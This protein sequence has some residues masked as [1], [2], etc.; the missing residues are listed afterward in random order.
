[1]GKS[2]D[3]RYTGPNATDRKQVDAGGLAFQQV[4]VDVIAEGPS[5]WGVSHSELPWSLDNYE[6][7]IDVVAS[8][9]NRF[10]AIEC[11][12]YAR[13]LRFIRS[14]WEHKNRCLSASRRCTTV[15]AGEPAVGAASLPLNWR[16][17]DLGPEAA[18]VEL[19]QTEGQLLETICRPLCCA[20]AAYAMWRL[21][22]GLKTDWIAPM[23]VTNAKLKVC[24]VDAKSFDLERG[25]LGE[26]QFEEV[27]HIRFHKA[28]LTSAQLD[29]MSTIG[30]W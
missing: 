5:D 17:V 13:P 18:L 8:N 23:I 12:R 28:F 6:G 26:A 21:S 16:E 11:K 10:L 14:T 2:T 24:T 9:S 27:Q 29:S 1:M 25:T 19:C 15:S 22:R 7:F 30:H 20:A 3:V 4:T